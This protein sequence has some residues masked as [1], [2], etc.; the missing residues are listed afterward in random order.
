[1][2][3][4]TGLDVLDAA[5]GSAAI[6]LLRANGASIDVLLLDLTIPGASSHEVLAEAVRVRPDIRV[7]LTSAYSK[8]ILTPRMQTPQIRG[9]IRKPYQIA[10]LVQVCRGAV[11]AID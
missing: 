2:L 10:D 3:R 9:F 7:I 1:M 6:E 11:A 8:E 4:R 5:N